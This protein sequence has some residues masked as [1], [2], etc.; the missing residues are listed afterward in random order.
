[1]VKTTLGPKKTKKRV[2]PKAKKST[3]DEGAMIQEILVQCPSKKEL[4][5]MPFAKLMKL[6][7]RLEDAYSRLRSSH[8]SIEDIE[9]SKLATVFSIR[10][11]RWKQEI[12]SSKAWQSALN[13]LRTPII[14]SEELLGPSKLVLKL[15]LSPD[16]VDVLL[17]K[18]LAAYDDDTRGYWSMAR[19]S[20]QFKTLSVSIGDTVDGDMFYEHLFSEYRRER[21]TDAPPFSA[22]I[23]AV[24]TKMASPKGVLYEVVGS[25]KSKRWVKRAAM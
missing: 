6:A 4:E 11:K 23:L 24:G 1:M 17:K 15:E 14:G 2:F 16:I 7:T 20:A 12:L 10:N 13:K 5:Q 22:S 9:H 8:L 25:C 18:V 3:V 19:S 21:T